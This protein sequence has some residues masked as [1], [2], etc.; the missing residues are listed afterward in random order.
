MSQNTTTALIH[1]PEE[2]TDL[3]ASLHTRQ[4]TP[5]FMR[6]LKEDPMSIAQNLARLLE[7]WATPHCQ[8]FWIKCSDLKKHI[9][10]LIFHNFNEHERSL[11]LWFRIDPTYQLRGFCTGAVQESLAS[12]LDENVWISK[13]IWRH[14][15][16]NKWSFHVFRKSGFH[17]AWFVPQQTYLPNI[18]Q[19]TDDFMWCIGRND[20]NTNNII[21]LGSS[22]RVDSRVGDGVQDGLTTHHFI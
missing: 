18:Q 16:R 13:V 22:I 14:S 21:T 19:T 9:W 8:V 12:I 4:K 17:L 20:W 1:A 5:D 10:M 15:A 6:F 2:V 11:E 3:A 7:E